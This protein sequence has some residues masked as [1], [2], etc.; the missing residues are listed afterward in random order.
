MALEK[1]GLEIKLQC[2]GPYEL[3]LCNSRVLINLASLHKKYHP[4]DFIDLQTEYQAKGL[5]LV[6][7]W[8]DIW[9]TRAAQVLGRIRSVLGL[10]QRIH[11]RQTKIMI[12][13]QQQADD[14]LRLHHL[15]ASARAKYKFAL[16][17]DGEIVAVACFSNLRPMKRLS[18]TYQSAELIR[19]ASLTGYTVTGGFRKLLKH[20]VQITCPD[21][22]MSYADRDWSDGN[23]YVKAGFVL[24]ETT[25]PADIWLNK[26]SFCRYFTHRLPADAM[27]NTKDYLNI[28]NTGNLKYILYL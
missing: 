21:D 9:H 22:I 18:A 12:I 23:A 25:A 6:H 14:F 10:N 13:N 4:L 8:E 1:M 2:H 7:L 5:L 26:N 15:Q 28:F 27:S 3:L 16:C 17:M 19:F 11:A 24:T 20:F